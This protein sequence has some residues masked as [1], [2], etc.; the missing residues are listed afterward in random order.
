M[1][2]EPLVLA[3]GES[4]GARKALNH[5]FGDGPGSLLDPYIREAYPAEISD[6]IKEWLLELGDHQAAGPEMKS[7]SVEVRAQR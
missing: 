6:V 5:L 2:F 7:L 1:N 4:R 3:F